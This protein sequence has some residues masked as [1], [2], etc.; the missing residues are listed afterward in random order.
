MKLFK[1]KYFY[2]KFYFNKIEVTNLETGETVSKTSVEKFSTKRIVIADFNSAE[3]LLREIIDSF[4]T[5]KNI[6]K[7]QF[8]VLMQ[9]MEEFEDGVSEIEKR[10]YR[11]LAEQAGTVKVFLL[12]HSKKLR[13]EEALSGMINNEFGQ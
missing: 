11:D 13:N 1:R 4:K 5:S 10:A 8:E 12:L 7:N 2:V 6:F 3:L 9:Q